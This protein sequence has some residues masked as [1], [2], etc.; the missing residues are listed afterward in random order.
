MAIAM[1]INPHFSWDMGPPVPWVNHDETCGYSGSCETGHLLGPPFLWALPLGHSVCD[2]GLKPSIAIWTA[3]HCGLVSKWIPGYHILVSTLQGNIMLWTMGFW[4]SE[5][6]TTISFWVPK[7]AN[8]MTHHREIAK[9]FGLR[10]I[11]GV[12]A[13]YLQDSGGCFMVIWPHGII[14]LAHPTRGW[15]VFLAKNH[16]EKC[17][18]L[19]GLPYQQSS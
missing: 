1:F 4:V 7:C 13:T 3:Q 19:G 18:W 9:F 11:H 10:N 8:C 16:R 17:W 12:R 5:V 15:T 14:I 6:E 2:E